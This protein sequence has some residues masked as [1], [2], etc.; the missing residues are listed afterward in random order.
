[1]SVVFPAPVWPTMARVCPGAMWKETS[2]KTQ[3][4][5]FGFAP[6]VVGEPHVA[7]FDV[8]ARSGKSQRSFR[9]RRGQRLVEQLEDAL[10][11]GHGRLQDVEFFAEVLNRAE[12]ALRV[13]HEG[14]ERSDRH[15]AG[16]RERPPY[17]KTIAMAVMLNS[18]TAGK[19]TAKAVIA[20]L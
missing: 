5:S 8:A 14:D 2:R 18:S 4:S 7:E 12:E 9:G 16:K 11:G 6:P 17:Q 1:M 20:S 13:L 15:R 10:A 3:S 19:K